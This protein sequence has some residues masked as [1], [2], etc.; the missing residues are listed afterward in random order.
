MYCLYSIFHMHC[1]QLKNRY[2]FLKSL[3]FQSGLL[4]FYKQNFTL[5]KYPH[6]NVI[7]LLSFFNRWKKPAVIKRL[8]VYTI[9]IYYIYMY[10]FKVNVCACNFCI[11]GDFG[12]LMFSAGEPALLWCCLLYTSWNESAPST[13]SETSMEPQ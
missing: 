3:R 9:N 11:K 6:G 5:L 7:Y 13:T 12:K 8:Y 1:L 4:L 2:Y 10:K